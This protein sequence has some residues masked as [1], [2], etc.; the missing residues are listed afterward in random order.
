MFSGQFFFTSEMKSNI[1]YP[2]KLSDKYMYHLLL[3]VSYSKKNRVYSS[4]KQIF[5]SAHYVAKQQ[6]T[7]LIEITNK[8]Q[9][10]RTIYY[11]IFP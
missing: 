6:K 10:C 1:K 4:T 8:M 5:Y 11:S 2:L 7:S 3:P 9:L